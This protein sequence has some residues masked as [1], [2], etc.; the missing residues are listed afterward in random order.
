MP[1]LDNIQ[2]YQFEPMAEMGSNATEMSEISDHSDGFEDVHADHEEE[3][4]RDIRLD[5]L[6]WQEMLFSTFTNLFPLHIWSKLFTLCILSKC[7]N[8]S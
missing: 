8:Q 2:P 6:A 7:E 1:S 4:S 5:N 3:E